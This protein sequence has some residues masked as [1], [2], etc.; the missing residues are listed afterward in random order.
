MTFFL[1]CIFPTKTTALYVFLADKVFIKSLENYVSAG[2]RSL[3]NITRFNDITE[4]NVSYDIKTKMNEMPECEE[5]FKKLFNPELIVKECDKIND[6]KIEEESK[7]KDFFS[8]Q[9]PGTNLPK[10]DCPFKDK[11]RGWNK[12]IA[13]NQAQLYLNLL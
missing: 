12:A 2:D 1:Y 4:V 5:V 13:R 3:L 9:K 10:L 6:D 8:N 7:M 11:T